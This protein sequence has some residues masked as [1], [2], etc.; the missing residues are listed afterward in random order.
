MSLNNNGVITYEDFVVSENEHSDA[1]EYTSDESETSESDND[2]E[3]SSRTFENNINQNQSNDTL[4]YEN[5]EK[6]DD[7]EDSDSEPEDEQEEKD[8]SD[9]IKFIETKKISNP[10]KKRQPKITIECSICADTLNRSNRKE[11][12]CLFCNYSACRSCIEQYLLQSSENVCMNC[13]AVWNREFLDEN[14]T[15]VFMKG[16]YKKRREDIL[17]DK[18]KALLQSTLP[19]AETRKNAKTRLGEISERRDYLYEQIRIM[20]EELHKMDNE[21]YRLRNQL[22]TTKAEDIQKKQF[23]KKCPNGECRGFLSTRWKCGLCNINV[24]SECHEIK[25][26]NNNENNDNIENNENIENPHVCK[27]ENVETA[28]LL[29][30]DCKNCPKCGTYIYKIEGC[31]GKD[32]EIPLWNGTIKKVQDIVTGD[33]L[34]GD[35]GSKRIVLNTFNGQD[36]LYEVQQNKGIN[37][38]VNSKHTLVLKYRKDSCIY[39]RNSTDCYNLLWFCREELRP[40]IKVFSDKFYKSKDNSE[41]ELLKFLEELK[42]SEY[43]EIK[44]DDYLK[45]EDKYKKELMGV[46]S[47]EYV[48]YEKRNINEVLNP[49]VLGLWLGDGIKNGPIISHNFKEDIEIREY[50]KNWCNENKLNMKE[51]E[52]SFTLYFNKGVNKRNI[53]L[54]AL[55]KYNLIDNKH[56]PDD[57]LYNTR[58]I[59]LQLLAGLIDTDG[60]S[61]QEGKRIVICQVRKELSN[62]ISELAK[63]LGF[64]VNCSIQH[65]KHIKCPK[66]TEYKD[67]DNQ[68]K[69]NISGNN[70]SDI[71]T[72]LARKKCINSTKDTTMTYINVVKK[73]FGNYY[74]FLLNDNHKFLL[75]ERTIQSNCN[76]MYCTNCH[77]AFSWTTGQI[78]T[79]RIHNPHYY[80]WLRKGGK[81]QRELLDIPC[82][83]MPQV[84]NMRINVEPYIEYEDNGSYSTVQQ[85]IQRNYMPSLYNTIRLVTHIQ[86]VNLRDFQQDIERIRGKE[87]DLRCEYLM[88]EIDEEEW[89]IT[90]QQNEYKLEYLTDLSQLYQ[91]FST[92][93]SDIVLYIYNTSI[94]NRPRKISSQT[95]IEKMDEIYELITY[96]N[97]H[98]EKLAR[99]FGKKKC[100]NIVNFSIEKYNV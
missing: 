8:E 69:V 44:V 74:G 11:I 31:F 6:K 46:K 95:I 1:Y 38:V 88:N 86:D 83:G 61:D 24:C 87:L 72:L 99:R 53:F 32:T 60:Y 90:L 91:M 20:N 71:P 97:N 63:S 50:L 94:N 78:E 37:Y 29:A 33:E 82:G 36:Q 66:S 48:K 98:S 22:T 18:Q 28:K 10:N 43:I 76:Q 56:I 64:I 49:Y 92:V 81:Q 23:V 14:L 41:K 55:K 3:D 25:E 21:S 84:Y 39:R 40:K 79:G 45:L 51:N 59:R 16:K 12:K 85:L 42:L 62:Q 75:T 9:E 58:E 7:Y 57:Y 54:D 68:Y 70:V 17:M 13:K 52:K 19:V 4:N 34:I 67:Y 15:K 80:E 65:K 26:T 96:F 73:E 89:K 77:T 27:P 2:D 100:D 47:I 5:D 30:K 35:N 93:S